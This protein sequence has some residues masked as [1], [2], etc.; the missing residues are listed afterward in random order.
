MS[1]G[2]PFEAVRDL[3]RE[4]PVAITVRGLSMAPRLRD[5]D[6]V[7]IAPARFYRPGDVVAFRNADGHLIVHRL[8]GYRLR[9]GR[10]ACVTRGD[11]AP[12]PDAPIPFA[13]LL[14][15]VVRVAHIARRTPR[16]AGLVTPMD[17]VRSV[18]GFLALAAA[19][20]GR[21]LRG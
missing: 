6:R 2:L 14:G 5:G 15:R 20:A 21:R 3:A 13:N 18:L 4:A 8:L 1:S 10:L 9:A 19:A 7:E 12:L 11:A 17:R 16:Q